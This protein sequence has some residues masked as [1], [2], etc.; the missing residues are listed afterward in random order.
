MKF[1]QTTSAHVAMKSQEIQA[2][3][4]R[5]TNHVVQKLILA[6]FPQ[7]YFALFCID[8]QLTTDDRLDM[9]S[10]QSRLNF[11]SESNVLRGRP[12]D[13]FDGNTCDAILHQTTSAL[14]VQSACNQNRHD[15]KTPD[16]RACCI[17]RSRALHRTSTQPCGL[18]RMHGCSLVVPCEIWAFDTSQPATKYRQLKHLPNVLHTVT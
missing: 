15:W 18:L 4:R 2:E 7:L 5:C 12:T 9:F 3:K 17:F 14:C 10:R 16:A 8:E 1:Q 6:D 13:G 11:F